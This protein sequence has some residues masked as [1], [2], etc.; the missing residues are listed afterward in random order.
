MSIFKS[1]CPAKTFV[2]GEYSA[3]LSQKAIVVL[4]EPR[5]RAEFYLDDSVDT[6]ELR[7]PPH[8]AGFVSRHAKILRNIHYKFFD[9]YASIG[10]LGASTAEF[11]FFF[12]AYS[13]FAGLGYDLDSLENKALLLDYYYDK[14]K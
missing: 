3:L 12:R 11:L 9:P 1:S 7:I 2:S 10:G 6:S 13:H 5:F 14:F 4:T 8:C